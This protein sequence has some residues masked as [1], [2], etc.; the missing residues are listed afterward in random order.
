MVTWPIILLILI[1]WFLK[2]DSE[3]NVKYCKEGILIEDALPIVKLSR[4]KK[5]KRVFGVLGKSSRNISR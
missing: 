5:E 3:L 1:K 4:K 2:D